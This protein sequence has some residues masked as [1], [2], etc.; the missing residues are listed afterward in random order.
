MFVDPQIY[1]AKVMEHALRL[2]AKTGMKVN[3]MYTPS[4]MM[5]VA[6]QITGKTFKARD[7]LG[8]ADALK[9]WVNNEKQV[10]I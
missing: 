8:A 5:R 7:Y 2:Y 10:S 1:R 6:N 3:T 9:E 4:A